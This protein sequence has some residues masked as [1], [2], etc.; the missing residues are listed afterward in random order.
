MSI[1]RRR[2][3]PPAHPQCRTAQV[4][5]VRHDDLTEDVASAT[6]TTRSARQCSRVDILAAS[7]PCSRDLHPGIPG[8]KGGLWP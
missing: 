2:L 1:E 5:L 4:F 6:L 8:V 7:W 3:Q